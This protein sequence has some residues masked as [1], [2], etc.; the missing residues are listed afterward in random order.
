MQVDL[1]SEE[2]EVILSAL[3][4]KKKFYESICENP[5]GITEKSAERALAVVGSL[6]EKLNPEVPELEPKGSDSEKSSKSKKFLYLYVPDGIRDKELE[7]ELASRIPET[8]DP[9]ADNFF[10]SNKFNNFVVK[11]KFAQSVREAVRERY[12]GKVILSENPE[13]AKKQNTW[14]IVEKNSGETGEE[15]KLEE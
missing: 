7:E 2:V 3:A 6:E 1:S 8:E 14:Q 13:W 11:T 4:E 9:E 12:N 10:W 15:T 5:N